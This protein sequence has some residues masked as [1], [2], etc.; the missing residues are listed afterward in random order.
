MAEVA[1]QPAVAQDQDRIVFRGSQRNMAVG[2]G[3]L[4]AGGLAFTMGLTHVFFAEARIT[5]LVAAFSF[6]RRATASAN[7]FSQASVMVL[8]GAP[9][10]SKVS[11]TMFSE[12]FS[13]LIGMVSSCRPRESGDPGFQRKMGSRFRG[14]DEFMLYRRSTIV[15]MPMPP[16]TQSVARP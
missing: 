3:M 16:P 4:V 6:P 5:P 10:A 8:T 13:N 9:G 2:V 1:Q 11:V 15:A 12:S 7:A 14:S